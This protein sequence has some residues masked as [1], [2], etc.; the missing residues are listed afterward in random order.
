MASGVPMI[1]TRIESHTQVLSDDVAI[2]AEPTTGGLAA[3]M[4]TALRDPDL[5][6]RR[7]A[8]A[9]E[10]YQKYYSRDVYVSKMSTLFERLG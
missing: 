1:A 3:G 10:W 8:R 7:A 2:L 9:R 5:A 6:R 4:L